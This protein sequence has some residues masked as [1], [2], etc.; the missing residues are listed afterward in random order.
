MAKRSVL[1]LFVQLNIQHKTQK[2]HIALTKLGLIVHVAH[3]SSPSVTVMS[4][5]PD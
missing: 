4:P 2:W 1:L 5:T 3:V